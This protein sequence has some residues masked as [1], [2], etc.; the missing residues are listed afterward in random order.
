M[1]V[2]FCPNCKVSPNITATEVR[3]P[4]CGKVSR[5]VD[6]TDTVSKWN[7]GETEAKK[8]VEVK[9]EAKVAEVKDEKVVEERPKRRRKAKRGE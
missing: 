5:G 8:T 6:L 7:N 1:K 9:A 3:C 2:S 4:K